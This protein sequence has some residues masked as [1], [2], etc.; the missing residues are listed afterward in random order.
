MRA[1]VILLAAGGGPGNVVATNLAGDNGTR[2]P[3]AHIDGAIPADNELSA[4]FD[5][6]PFSNR[7]GLGAA[8][9]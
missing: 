7:S 5:K 4:P 6:Y 2:L 1:Q 3:R 8:P 9:V